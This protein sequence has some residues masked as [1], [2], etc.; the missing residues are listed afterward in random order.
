[1]TGALLRR[2][3]GIVTVTVTDAKGRPVRAA[4]I[5]ASGAGARARS[6][7][8]GRR[9]TARFKLRPRR[10]GTLVFRARKA[11]YRAARAVLSIG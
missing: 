5:R 4:R 3:Q 9:G 2:R 6:K 8:S 7:R 11:G 10:K 1:V